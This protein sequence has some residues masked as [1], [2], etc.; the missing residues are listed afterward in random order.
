MDA[1]DAVTNPHLESRGYFE[2]VD[3]PEIG[4]HRYPGMFFKFSETPLKIRRHAPR[5]GEDNE[6]V[7][8]ELLQYSD[9]EYSK[10]EQ[11]GHIGMDYA[12]HVP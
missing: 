5:L 11:D 1:R 12:P 2:A 6:Y 4:V 3:H 8:K 10:F 7:Y 9:E